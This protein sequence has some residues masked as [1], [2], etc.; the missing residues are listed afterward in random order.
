ME[1]T[2]EFLKKCGTYYIAT[3]DG[4]R[5]RVRPFG[6]VH[7]FEGKLYIQTGKIKKVS[8]QMHANPNIEISAFIGDKWIRLEATAVED[9]RLEAQ[10]SML[11]E[12][13]SLQNMYKAGDG[14][15]EV[16]YLKD[17]AARIISLG[18][19]VVTENF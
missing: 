10:Q 2:Y 7:I 19:E 8:K 11:D 9:E 6:T 14:N 1:K 16:W 17:A 15:T 12:Y 13:P 5:P 4:D 18:G 3:I